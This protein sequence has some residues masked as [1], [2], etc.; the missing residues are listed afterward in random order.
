MIKLSQNSCNTYVT[1]L[2]S[3]AMLSKAELKAISTAFSRASAAQLDALY[4]AAKNCNCPTERGV[5]VGYEENY[6]SKGDGQFYK[7]VFALPKSAT[8]AIAVL[9]KA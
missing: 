1:L 2:K 8:E 6:C 3:G 7:P 9:A 5:L 4:W